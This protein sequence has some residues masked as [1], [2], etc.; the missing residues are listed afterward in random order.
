MLTFRRQRRIW[1]K[2][3]RWPGFGAG[4]AL[5]L[6]LSAVVQFGTLR[7]SERLGGG[8]FLEVN[9][10]CGDSSSYALAH[11]FVKARPPFGLRRDDDI[12]CEPVQ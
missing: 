5:G 3:S 1:R 12:T 6:A 7:A 4:L 8:R 9:L 2:R 10:E 11:R